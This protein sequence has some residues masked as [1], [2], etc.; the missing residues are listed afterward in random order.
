[1]SEPIEHTFLGL[2]AQT[3]P[4][5]QKLSLF[6]NRFSEDDRRALERSEAL[7]GCEVCM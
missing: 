2:P 5:L 1:M 4:A 6:G 3:D 7:R